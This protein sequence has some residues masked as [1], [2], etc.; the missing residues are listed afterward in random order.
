MYDV[1]IWYCKTGVVQYTVCYNIT[2]TSGSIF[3]PF[4]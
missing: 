4:L 1:V 2:L 3:V